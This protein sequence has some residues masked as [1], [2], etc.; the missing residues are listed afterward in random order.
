MSLPCPSSLS[1][2]VS[3]LCRHLY[4]VYLL[5]SILY[6]PLAYPVL[7]PYSE[8]EEEEE[9]EDEEEE[10]EEEEVVTQRSGGPL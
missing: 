3:T 1:Y 4:L 7:H 9:E 2:I 8:E 5:I 10:E 6:T